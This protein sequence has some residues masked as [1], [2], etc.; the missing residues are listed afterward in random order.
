MPDAKKFVSEFIDF[1]HIEPKLPGGEK[2]Y[3]SSEPIKISADMSREQIID[4][5]KSIRGTNIV[6]DL[7]FY[8]YRDMESCDWKP[9]I[10]SAI[11]RSPVSIEMTKDKSIEDCFKWLQS[12][13]NE[14]IYDGK[15]V[16]QPDEVANY[17]RGDGIEK[18]ITL[19]NIIHK[20]EPDKEISV[21]ING[22]SIVVEAGKRFEFNSLKQFQKNILIKGSEYIIQ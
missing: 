4:Y 22:S 11:E 14:S 16:A 5:L 21:R 6:A 20:R 18:A 12:L 7:A 9:F 2:N 19:A 13:P 3:I 15:R 1:I 8:A 10:K 17:G